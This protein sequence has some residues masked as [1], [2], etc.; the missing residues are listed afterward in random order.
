MKLIKPCTVHHRAKSLDA[1]RMWQFSDNS[2]EGE[3]NY[4]RTN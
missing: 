4:D 2:D 3:D 1:P